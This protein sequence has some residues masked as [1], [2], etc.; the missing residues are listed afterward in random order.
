MESNVIKHSLVHT[1]TY[2]ACIGIYDTL[3]ND[4]VIFLGLCL[5]FMKGDRMN[6]KNIMKCKRLKPLHCLY[7]I[8]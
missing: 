1:Y 4:D 5:N 7:I 8:G 3:G 2:V 6:I